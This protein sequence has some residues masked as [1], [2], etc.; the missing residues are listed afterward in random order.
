M[1]RCG[2]H[3]FLFACGLALFT[4]ILPLVRAD[5]MRFSTRSWRV[6]H[7]VPDNFINQVVQDKRGYLWVGTAAGLAR[8]DSVSFK[9]FRDPQ[10]SGDYGFNIRDMAMAPDGAILTLPASGGVVEWR[11]GKSSVHPVSAQLGGL[12][13]IDL[14]VEPG[15]AIWVGLD[16]ATLVRWEKGEVRRFGKA[17][18]VNRRV[19]RA[20]FAVDGR[21]RTWVAIGEFLGWYHDGNLVPVNQPMT[22]IGT[23]VLV[24][25]S[26]SGGLWV[27]SAERLLRLDNDHATPVCETPLW[28]AKRAGI[29]CLFEDSTGRLWVGTR[30]EG[31]FIYS[32]GEVKKVALASRMIQSITEDT[33]GNIWVGTAGEGLCRLRPQTFTILNAQ[34]GLVEDDSTSV[35]ADQ[36][37]GIWCANRDGGL[38]RYKDGAVQLFGATSAGGRIFASR[39]APDSEGN[40]WLGSNT[41]VYRIVGDPP[42]RLELVQST[43]RGVHILHGGRDGKMWVD[44]AVGFGFF[45][46][47]VY[48][49]VDGP[50]EGPRYRVDALAENSQG[51]IWIAT[52]E[53][54]NARHQIRIHEYVDGNLVERMA[55]DQ[56]DSG[57]IHTL[58]FDHNDGLWIGSAGGLVLKQGSKITRFSKA[59]GL[60]DD[61]VTQIQEDDSGHLWM[62]GRR[63]LFRVKIDDLYAVAEGKTSRVVAALFGEDDGLQEAAAPGGGQ[64][65]S[66]K[67]PD[68]RLWFTLHKGVVGVVPAAITAPRSAPP[69]YIEEVMLDRQVYPVT[70][71]RLEV[72]TGVQQIKIRL[73]VL[74]FSHPEHVVLRYKLEG[75]DREWSE[76][77]QDRTARYTHLPPGDYRLLVQAVNQSGMWAD[78]EANLLIH[79]SAAWWQTSWFIVAVIVL[80]LAVVAWV[81]RIWSVRKL[82]ARLLRL[83]KE[84]ALERERARIARNL[85]DELGGSLT[86]IG[87]L[88]ERLKRHRNM[89]EI[90]KTLGLLIRRTQGLA[91]D[92]ESIV[93]TV[94]PQNNSWDR[95][96]SFI[97]RYARLFF[98][99]S[100]IAC[101]LEGVEAISALPLTL[102]AQHEVLAI[103]KE[104]LN[105]VLKHSR[106]ST[107]SLRFAINQNVFEA[108]IQDDGVGFEPTLQE[109]S[110]RNGLNNMRTRT[111]ELNGRLV[112]ESRPGAGTTILLHIPVSDGAETPAVNII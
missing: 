27:S 74:D 8:F 32:A 59:N 110:E 15:G 64:P 34:A 53:S 22:E 56:W 62:A 100:G 52:S 38:A 42:E 44:S 91:V 23:A 10:T 83:E 69:L 102:E 55:P 43:T 30:R 47:R 67:S 71:P 77:D 87:L 107:V 104:A 105:N 26:R 39:V 37:G 81:A 19:N 50:P 89:E 76:T 7:G 4:T 41:G 79:V 84:H 75:F 24:A 98:D 12:T 14:F 101:R 93:W 90:E 13:P 85:H 46:D 1:S 103:C 51:A 28:P 54:R 40:I 78:R 31:L 61:L 18:G 86:Q 33:E 96:A 57:S 112:I 29:Q 17:E 21:G 6:E 2:S 92:L 72:P 66:W 9:E 82:K 3:S 36:S 25:P 88:A 35:C 99:G 94:S 108:T 68:G 95:L 20:S 58:F 70:E 48:T 11:D 60:P 97:G 16:P 73:A 109:H 45:R 111:A 49:R 63:A 65:R 106:A 5:D 80:V